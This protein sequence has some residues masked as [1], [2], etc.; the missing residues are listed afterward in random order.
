MQET[1]VDIQDF[2]KTAWR[3]SLVLL[4]A[5]LCCHDALG[6]PTFR[7][8]SPDREG[9]TNLK[10]VGDALY[11]S[12]D[13]GLTGR[14]LWRCDQNDQVSLVCD[15]YPGPIGSNPGYVYETDSALYYFGTWNDAGSERLALVATEGSDA[16]TRIVYTWSAEV[17]Y[18][19]TGGIGGLG[20]AG[21]VGNGLYFVLATMETGSELWHYSPDFNDSKPYML[22]E[23]LPGRVS[24]MGSNGMV[25]YRDAILFF[26]ATPH[27]DPATT[28]DY[29]LYAIEKDGSSPRAIPTPEGV[30]FRGEQYLHAVSDDEQLYFADV[31]GGPGLWS[32][33]VE[34]TEVR[35]AIEPALGR[36]STTDLLLVDAGV[37]VNSHSNEHGKELWFYDRATEEAHLVVDTN[38]GQADASPYYLARTARGIAYAAVGAGIGTEFYHYDL[39]DNALREYDL[40]SGP[41]GSFPYHLKTLGNDVLFSYTGAEVGE[42]LFRLDGET[43]EV[44]LVKDINPGPG[45]SEPYHTTP[46]NDGLYF[47]VQSP[48]G[49]SELWKTNG[50]ESG[51]VVIADFAKIPLERPSDPV[52]I[53]V[54]DR[55]LYFIASRSDTGRE[56]WRIEYGDG[57]PRC[58]TDLDLGISADG[59][60]QHAIVDGHLYFTDTGSSQDPIWVDFNSDTL[61]ATTLAVNPLQDTDAVL[62]R[63]GE[64][65]DS[66]GV[67]LSDQ[68]EIFARWDLAS[69]QELWLKRK[70]SGVANLLLDIAPGP[71]SSSPSLLSNHGGTVYFLAYGNAHQKSLWCVK[72]GDFTVRVNTGDPRVDH[73]DSIHVTESGLVLLQRQGDTNRLSHY[74]DQGRIVDLLSLWHTAEGQIESVMTLPDAI[75]VVMNHPRYGREIWCKNVWEKDRFRLLMK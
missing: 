48:L 29:F 3:V 69:G 56:L 31:H 62:Y 57:V 40:N 9:I 49:A 71:A 67:R 47:V 15:L 72:G 50:T 10:V 59:S 14:E 64:R 63:Q 24:G 38:P 25:Q 23:F 6:Q 21:T 41:N 51:T 44:S 22:P 52:L 2:L 27:S 7:V 32:V 34:R 20:A 4:C 17:Q 70:D 60:L 39:I 45:S 33:D 73:P 66:T 61:D 8:P 13:D 18:Q 26:A 19:A 35:A 37:F 43:L 46:F 65:I 42:E 74:R 1:E 58:M 36:I 54:M 12:A 68:S 16:T 28:I 75:V 55:A 5:C 30:P 11:F 53:G